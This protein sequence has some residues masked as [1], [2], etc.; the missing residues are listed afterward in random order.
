[1]PLRELG[2]PENVSGKHRQPIRDISCPGGLRFGQ[3]EPGNTSYTG[4]GDRFSAPAATRFGP[5]RRN[6]CQNVRP[7][8]A[9]VSCRYRTG[10]RASP[11]QL[12]PENL[13]LSCINRWQFSAPVATVFGLAMRKG[14]QNV[15]PGLAVIW[16]RYYRGI[17]S[18]PRPPEP[19]NRI[20][21]G[22]PAGFP[23]WR[24]AS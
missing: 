5:A 20:T 8:L 1:M 21:V 24:L 22:R 23:S 17:R 15:R 13:L 19:K 18:S 4:E 12:G 14:Y 7:G 2:C 16:C 11:W 10:I 3:Q 6:R 9:V